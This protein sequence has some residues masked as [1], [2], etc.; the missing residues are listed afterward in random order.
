M[1]GVGTGQADMR[2]ELGR[3]A[4]GGLSGARIWDGGEEQYRWEDGSGW[5][6][7]ALPLPLSI[8]LPCGAAL[9]FLL[10]SIPRLRL[11]CQ[12]HLCLERLPFLLLPCEAAPLF[13]SGPLF[14]STP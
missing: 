11:L 6:G 8:S 10:D 4:Q 12:L 2:N 5:R 9:C 14:R 3:K 13:S 7:H 1:G